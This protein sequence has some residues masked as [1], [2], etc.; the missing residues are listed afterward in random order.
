MKRLVVCLQGQEERVE[1]VGRRW[2]LSALHLV[3]Q[4]LGHLLHGV[5]NTRH[6]VKVTVVVVGKRNISS[7]SAFTKT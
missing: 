3:Q 4:K 2:Y 6:V 5:D 7:R 1:A